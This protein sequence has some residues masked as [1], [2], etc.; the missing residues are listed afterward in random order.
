[1]F[2]FV[3]HGIDPKI[4]KI[5]KKLIHS[6]NFGRIDLIGLLRLRSESKKMQ[7]E[8]GLV[9]N[10]HRFLK[11]DAQTSLTEPLPR[12]NIK[13]LI[14]NY[15]RQ[16]NKFLIRNDQV[17]VKNMFLIVIFLLTVNV[18]AQNEKGV[19]EISIY[20]SPLEHDNLKNSLRSKIRSV[21]LHEKTDYYVDL[22]VGN[23][24]CTIAYENLE[25]LIS[26]IQRLE[27]KA[28]LDSINQEDDVK[29]IVMTPSG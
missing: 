11:K 4:A 6:W 3:H 15:F 19:K 28:T 10:N 29:N 26:G 17:M 24:Y 14:K 18:C 27:K 25:D 21:R 23:I 7:P 12:R 13:D 9:A 1:M 5:K 16:K 22:N 20:E 2:F 8:N